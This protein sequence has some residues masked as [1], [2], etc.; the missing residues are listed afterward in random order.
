MDAQASRDQSVKRRLR[1]QID[2]A[3]ISEA[4]KVP[5]ALMTAHSKPVIHGLYWH[6]NIF[7]SF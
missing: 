1:V 4:M 6:L 7:G 3:E 5:F 2:S